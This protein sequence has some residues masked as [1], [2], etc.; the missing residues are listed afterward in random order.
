MKINLPPYVAQRRHVRS[1][2]GPYRGDKPRITLVGSGLL[3]VGSQ[4]AM[5][6]A[7]REWLKKQKAK[8]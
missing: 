3:V 5:S 2:I 4:Q 1:N 7:T 6:D 8:K